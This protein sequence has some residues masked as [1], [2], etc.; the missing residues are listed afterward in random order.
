MNSQKRG[1]QFEIIESVK[2]DLLQWS[3]SKGIRLCHL[4]SVVPFVETD[5]TLHTVFFY[6]TNA[7]V[8]LYKGNGT[9]NQIIA[10][11]F[12][13]LRRFGSLV[14]HSKVNSIEFDSD[15]NVKRNYQGSYFH[16]MR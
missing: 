7:D 1:R 11:Y 9:S 8:A 14:E 15:E 12:D 2:K 3:Q 5:D 6:E 16:R 4:E 13:L 10:Y